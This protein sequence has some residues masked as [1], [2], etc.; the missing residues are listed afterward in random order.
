[1]L[2]LHDI[3]FR[4]F[5]LLFVTVFL[6]LGVIFYFWIRNICIDETKTD[7]LH[8]IEILSFQ[9]NDFERANEVAQALSKRIK[10]LR[11]TI[12][13]SDGCVLG[14]SHQD[15]QLMDNHRDR[16]EIVASDNAPYGF[17]IRYSK[18]LQK[19]LLYLSKRYRLANETYYLRMARDINIFNQQFF[20]LSLKI[21][22]LFL[23]FMG[24]AFAMALKISKEVENETTNILEFLK[25]L[26][27]QNK[28]LK[29]N[30]T[31]SKEFYK[32]T[33]LLS[34][35]SKQLSKRNQKKAKYTAKLKLSN[36]QKDE[37]ISAISHE[38]KNPIAV[39][40]GY[41][42]TLQEAT[43]L[44]PKMRE[45]FLAKIASNTTKLTQMI[46]RLRLSI[47][48]DEGKQSLQ[49]SAVDL[50]KLTQEVIEDLAETYPNREMVVEVEGGCVIEVDR[51]LFLIAIT[52]LIENAL[53]YSEERVIIT[54]TSEALCVID[55]GVGIE[56]SEIAKITEKFYRVSSNRWNNS[57][58]VGLSLVKH[59]VTIHQLSLNIDSK[60]GVGS[61][62]EINFMR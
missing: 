12:I 5:L 57:L 31:Y 32:I 54:I 59:I 37:I 41:T 22:L 40:H 48:L 26:S 4:K 43:D 42:Q 11:V 6:I 16:E 50:E 49:L 51:T 8:N 10:D 38:F 52:N 45:K 56:E 53:K 1:L 44:N 27:K 62:F 35:I 9:I 55:S 46:D 20:S 60:E 58:G 13:A 24:I 19:R 61:T 29:I 34:S 36:R 17:S 25:A 47:K 21:G 7:L 33:E 2:K 14:E 39:I 30:S 23:L 3:F 18:T 15:Y 28:V